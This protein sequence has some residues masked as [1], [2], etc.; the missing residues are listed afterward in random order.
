MSSNNQR[1]QHIEDLCFFI[2]RTLLKLKITLQDVQYIIVLNYPGSYT[3][4]RLA[5]SFANTARLVFGTLISSVTKFDVLSYQTFKKRPYGIVVQNKLNQYVIRI[6]NDIQ[7]T[8]CH[9]MNSQQI[10]KYKERL[11]LIGDADFLEKKLLMQNQCFVEYVTNILFSRSF[12][13]DNTYLKTFN[14]TLL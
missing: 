6:F 8:R 5:I 7:Y 9:V 2:T 14:E 4:I 3:S 13:R 1:N 11:H 10:L 12:K